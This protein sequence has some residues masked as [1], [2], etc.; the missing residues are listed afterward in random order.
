MKCLKCNRKAVIRSRIG[1]LCKDHFKEYY[2]NEIKKTIKKYNMFDENSRILVAVSGGKDSSALAYA[3]NEL[4]FKFEGLYINLEIKGYSEKCMKN[5]EELFDLLDKKLNII[6]VSDYG[7]KIRRVGPRNVCSVC[8]I[9]KRYLMNKFAYENKFDVLVTAHNLTD[10]LSF[11][12]NNLYSNTIEYFVKL[13]PVSER[14]DKLVKKVKPLFFITEKE[15]LVF[16]IINK[17]NFCSYRCP[18]SKGTTQLEW[19]KI[20]LSIENVKKDIQYRLVRTLLNLKRNIKLKEEGYHFCK[21][22]GYP[23]KSK[24]KICS[25]CKIKNYF[26]SFKDIKPVEE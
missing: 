24:D 10:I 6:N 25:F 2:L 19:K 4:G 17:I 11:F 3:L 22:C 26:K 13:D 7:V 15:N 8:G 5:V 12:F 16:C 9:V 21:V 23:T 20:I 18:Y 1:Y 14:K